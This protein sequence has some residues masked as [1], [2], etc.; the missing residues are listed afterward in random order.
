MSYCEAV[1]LES[2]KFPCCRAPRDNNISAAMLKLQEWSSSV[3]QS[4]SG[5]DGDQ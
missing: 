2:S 1:V 3:I 5:L 4:F